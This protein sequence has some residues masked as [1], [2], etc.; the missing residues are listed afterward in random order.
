MKCNQLL[1]AAAVAAVFVSCGKDDAKP[2]ANAAALMGTYDFVGMSSV[3]TSTLIVLESN[4]KSVTYSAYKTKNNTGTVVV[5]ASTFVST[6][7]AYSIDTVIKNEYWDEGVLEDSQELPY[8]VTAPAAGSTLTYKWVGTDSVHFDKGFITVSD[9]PSLNGPAQ[10]SGARISWSG[11]TLILHSAYSATVTGQQSGFT[12][13]STYNAVQ[14]TKL[15]K[16]K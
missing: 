10:E 5:D 3:G 14:E 9:D 7:M 12:V 15:K 11:D 8:K 16:R 6:N 2:D 1:L 4:E 13:I